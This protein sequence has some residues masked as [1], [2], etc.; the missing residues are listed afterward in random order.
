LVDRVHRWSADQWNAISP[1]L[2]QAL[3]LEP[4]AR[5]AWLDQLGAVN[6]ALADDLRELLATH[7]TVSSAQ[8]LDR[9]LL[10]AAPDAVAGQQF[11]AYTLESLIGNGA[12]GSVWLARHRDGGFESKAAIRILDH[13]G[14][15]HEGADQIRREADPLTRHS[16]ANIARLFNAGFTADGQ[17]YLILE[18]VE[19]VRIDEYC[20]RRALSLDAR[21]AL[22]LPI[23]DAVA[24]A[25]ASGIVHRDLKPTNILVTPDGVPKLLDLGVASLISRSATLATA[26]IAKT[27]PLES[28]PERVAHGATPAFAAPE[29]IRGEAVTPASDVYALGILLHLLITG[30]HP[31]A[32]DGATPTQIIRA[33]LTDD[34]PLASD[35]VD[36]VSF[37][38]LARGDLDAVASK[39]IH[40][41]P[42]G[43]YA[44]AAEL[45]ADIR[46][47][48]G[49]RPVSARR[50]NWA[51]RIGMF[52]MRVR[53][54]SGARRP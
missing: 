52:A 9:A 1:Y 29:Q 46:R 16:H 41:E 43:R 13:G 33:V 5:G 19:G 53:K 24:H 23:V 36:S 7:D 27:A 45:A 14:L 47:F 25:H 37:R 18:Y 35:A 48:R 30:R 11:G 34:A 31:F 20:D 26:A 22:L 54:M 39:A 15:G 32:A 40:R 8:F 44:S 12:S 21:L 4:P 17:A 49:S 50:H 6:P 51:Q 2:D 38:R 28:G 10:S 3:D 42:D